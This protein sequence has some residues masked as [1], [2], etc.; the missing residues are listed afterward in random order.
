ME[1]IHDRVAGLDV[2]R[3]SISAC[4]RLPGQRGSAVVDKARFA[5]TTAGLA[6]LAE[7][8]A[9]RQVTVVGLEAT[10]VYVR[11]ITA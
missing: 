2:H 7:W 3:D 1:Q 11:R 9:E 4:A 5:T 6:A 10:G 8:L